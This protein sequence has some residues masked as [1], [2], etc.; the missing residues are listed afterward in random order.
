MN[1]G[2]EGRS[3]R[4]GCDVL[5]SYMVAVTQD[6]TARRLVRDGRVLSR[7]QISLQNVDI[8]SACARSAVHVSDRCDCL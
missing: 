3:D 1:G 6:V 4:P 5:S 7:K 8:L 2:A